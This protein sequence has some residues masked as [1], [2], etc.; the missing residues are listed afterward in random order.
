MDLKTYSHET[1]PMLLG[2]KIIDFS[3]D[4]LTLNLYFGYQQINNL[5]KWQ[6]KKDKRYFLAHYNMIN[7]KGL[8]NENFKR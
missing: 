7:I 6:N 4:K 2:G 1:F 8:F 5:V 3:V